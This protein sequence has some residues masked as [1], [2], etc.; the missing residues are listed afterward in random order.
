[1]GVYGDN[2]SGEGKS[3]KGGIRKSPLLIERALLTYML[4]TTS[5]FA[6]YMCIHIL[7]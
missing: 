4:D 1:M 3:K 6:K 2:V 7:I 5:C